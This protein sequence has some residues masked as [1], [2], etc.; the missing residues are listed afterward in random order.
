MRKRYVLIIAVILTIALSACAASTETNDSSQASEPNETT[1][2]AAA[3]DLTIITDAAPEEEKEKP[4]KA[5]L[6]ISE[7]WA[8]FLDLPRSPMSIYEIPG[9]SANAIDMFEAGPV[10]RSKVKQ[11]Q[12]H[13]G[14]DSSWGYMNW[15]TDQ[16]EARSFRV[17][18][19]DTATDYCYMA[20][21]EGM[22]WRVEF[23]DEA[24]QRLWG[25]S[26]RVT[27]KEELLNEF[28]GKNITD[29]EL[30]S[31][32]STITFEYLSFPFNLDSCLS[33]W[34]GIGYPGVSN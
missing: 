26:Y 4:V 3:D 5:N 14:T 27:T 20:T 29:R 19:T 16:E 6:G 17:T 34:C 11:Q 25:F 22:V 24:L 31:G 28:S 18:D 23:T 12:E 2:A 8:V 9:I 30:E 13:F 15:N 10:P 32:F 33:Y 1:I 7:E 21:L